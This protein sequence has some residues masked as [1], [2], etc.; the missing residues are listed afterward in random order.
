MTMLDERNSRMVLFGAGFYG[1]VAIRYISA[2]NIDY[3]VDNNKKKVGML[4][5]VPVYFFEDKKDE[6]RRKQIVISVS[7][8]RVSEIRNQL[9]AC[10]VENV[11]SYFELEQKIIGENFYHTRDTISIYKDALEW[12]YSHTVKDG[13]IINNTSQPFPYPEVTG[14]YIPSLLFW[15]HRDI[16][17]QYAK[18]LCSIQKEDGSWCDTDDLEPFVFDTAQILKGLIAIRDFLPEIDSSII[19]GCDWMLSKIKENGQLPASNP[20]TWGDGTTMS[21]LIHLYCLSPLYEAGRILCE[22]SYIDA[23]NRVKEYYLTNFKNRILDF[24]L[25]SHFYAYVIEGLI[26]VGETELARK[27]MKNLEQYQNEL[28]AVSAYNDVNWVCST[29]LFQFSVIWFRLGDFEKG[30]KAFRYACSLQN[31]TGGWYGSY[32][33]ISGTYEHPRYFPDSEI[34]WAVKYFLDA[35]KFRY[36]LRSEKL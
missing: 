2:K 19:R 30:E 36:T 20:D 4:D 24:H 23:A 15:K 26:D 28:G 9:F 31:G 27:A 7:R 11:C 16:A 5:G 12:I 21:E 18:W 33:P 1:R 22:N 25:M 34:S 35:L 3:V 32:P 29:G 13:G 17:I 6:L 8:E 10:G 14:Y